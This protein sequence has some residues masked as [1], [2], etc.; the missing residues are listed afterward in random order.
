MDI[1]TKEKAYELY[2]AGVYGNKP[3]TW[4]T[5]DD[6]YASGWTKG[7][8]PRYKG[9][10]GRKYPG[11]GKAMDA[12]DLPALV[13]RWVAEEKADPAL[14]TI[15]ALM[16]DDK[17]IFQGEVWICEREGW[18]LRYSTLP[19]Q[20]REAL[21]KGEQHKSGIYAYLF[22]QLHMDHTS[23]DRL[24]ELLGEHPSAII[25]LSVWSVP[26]G[27]LGWNTIIWEVRHY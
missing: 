22:L 14:I 26:V 8:V 6:F 27:D 2:E 24:V 23:F 19:T 25:E 16:P 1:L 15:G 5:L 7:I 3:R 13:E 18:Y 9:T 20:M 17:I 21:E 11:Y 10:G 12:A 4:P